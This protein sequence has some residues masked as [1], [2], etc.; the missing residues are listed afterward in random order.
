MANKKETTPKEKS[1]FRRFGGEKETAPEPKDKKVRIECSS[2][3]SDW[4]PGDGPHP[5]D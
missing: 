2:D 1:A 3:P 4:R 5:S